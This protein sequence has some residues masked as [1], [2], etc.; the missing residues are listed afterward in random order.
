MN[1]NNNTILGIVLVVLVVLGG[2]YFFNRDATTTPTT[3]N[4][5]STNNT[6]SAD[7]R[8]V[9]TVTDAALDMSTISAIDMT[10][11]TV[12]VHNEADGWVQVS[13]VT[14]TYNL[15]ELDAKN[16]S[17]IIAD[18]KAKADTYDQVR[19]AVDKIVVRTKDGA[20]KE[21]KLPSGDIKILTNLVVKGGSTSTVSFDFLADKSLRMTGDGQYVFAPVIK[22]ETRSDATVAISGNTVVTTGGKVDTDVAVGMDIDGSIKLNFELKADEKLQIKNGILKSIVY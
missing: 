9:F 19:L 11:S 7:G 22:A 8:V 18:I 14:H 21:A 13:N 15:L 5:T 2:I 3:Q 10:V 20:S 17:K 6:S 16:E 1:N 4:T 12:Q